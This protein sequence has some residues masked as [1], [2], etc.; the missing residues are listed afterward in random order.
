MCGVKF[1]HANSVKSKMWIINNRCN[2]QSR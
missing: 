2:N 1:G